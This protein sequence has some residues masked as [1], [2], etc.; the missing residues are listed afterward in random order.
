MREVS[1]L[2][3][4]LNGVSDLI[5]RIDDDVQ[6][7]DKTQNNQQKRTGEYNGQISC[8]SP[9]CPV[10]YGFI[11]HDKEMPIHPDDV[12]LKAD[13]LFSLDGKDAEI[14]IIIGF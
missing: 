7:D 5:D 6:N 13:V 2:H 4:F 11:L 10:E 9:D 14:A 8:Y 3:N 1:V 12:L